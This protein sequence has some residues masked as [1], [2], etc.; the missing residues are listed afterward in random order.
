VQQ[1]HRL[2]V[3]DDS[4]ETQVRGIA[5]KDVSLKGRNNAMS[6]TEAERYM[7]TSGTYCIRGKMFF[8]CDADYHCVNVTRSLLIGDVGVLLM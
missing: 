8:F 6:T 5:S 2:Q 3:G 1:N 4:A 7:A